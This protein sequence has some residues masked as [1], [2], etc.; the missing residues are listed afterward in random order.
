MR[1]RYHIAAF[2]AAL[3]V[4]AAGVL[5]V[6]AEDQDDNEDSMRP[7]S[8]MER[9]QDRQDH[10]EEVRQNIQDRKDDRQEQKEERMEN[11]QQLRS[12]VAEK[13]ANRLKNRFGF[14]S[15][16][17]NN[18]LEKLETRLQNMSDEGKDVTTAEEKLN[19]AKTALEEGKTLADQAVAAFN[20]IDPEDYETQRDKALAARDIAEEARAKFKEAVSLMR[21]AVSLAKD[22]Q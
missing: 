1:K 6:F 22:A 4:F 21:E 17:L 16:R 7:S 20:A 5:Q 10:M 8:M 3:A 9:R 2:A 18:L 14:Y 12:D 13:H 15:N 11:R 19:A